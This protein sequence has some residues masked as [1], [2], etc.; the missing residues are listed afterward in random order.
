LGSPEHESVTNIG[1]VSAEGFTGT[2]D[3]LMVPELPAVSTNGNADG[4]TGESTSWKLGVV[5]AWACTSV[6]TDD[7]PRCVVSPL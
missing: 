1:D 2:I 3:T 6:A 7:E 4:A 5:E